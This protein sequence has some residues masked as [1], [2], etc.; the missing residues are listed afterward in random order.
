M[1][2]SMYLIIESVK[3]FK[4]FLKPFVDDTD[5]ILELIGE[6]ESRHITVN[7]FGITL[8]GQII[9]EI[10]RTLKWLQD[11]ILASPYANRLKTKTE[12]KEFTRGRNV[13]E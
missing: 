6:K 8:D 7:G 2:D 9:I 5:L 13:L 12:I 3:E 10:P 11:K 4:K 1:T